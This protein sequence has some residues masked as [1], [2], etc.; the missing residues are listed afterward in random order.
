MLKIDELSRH[1]KT[2]RQLECVSLR[3]RSPL[4]KSACCV[5]PP[6]AFWAGQNGGGGRRSV[7]ARRRGRGGGTNGR[8]AG[9]PGSGASVTS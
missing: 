9:V 7:V 3:E 6:K 2:W 4:G 8:D 1:D 5:F